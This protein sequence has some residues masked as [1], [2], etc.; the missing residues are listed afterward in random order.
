MSGGF[1][2]NRD[3]LFHKCGFR[4]ERPDFQVL[5]KDE[6]EFAS[7]VK[8]LS[9]DVSPS[10]YIDFDMAVATSQSPVDARSITWR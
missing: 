6:E 2:S 1:R 4:K 8:E 5:D 7:L 9:L 10:E 3:Q